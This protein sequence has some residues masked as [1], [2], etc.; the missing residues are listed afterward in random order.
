MKLLLLF[1]QAQ[2]AAGA[3]GESIP[4]TDGTITAWIWGISAII[5]IGIIVRYHLK[6]RD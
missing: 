4:E 3:I 1:Q 5:G 6:N 2:D